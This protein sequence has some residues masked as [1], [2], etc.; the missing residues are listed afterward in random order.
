MVNGN[1]YHVELN[2]RGAGMRLGVTAQGYCRVH[3]PPVALDR[4]INN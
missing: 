2:I 3:V 1:S 4:E